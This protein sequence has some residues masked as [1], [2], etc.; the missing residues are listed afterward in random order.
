MAG[1]RGKNEYRFDGDLVRFNLKNGPEAVIDAADYSKIKDFHWCIRRTSTGGIVPEACI[2]TRSAPTE[3]CQ[4]TLGR[5][6]LGA[7]PSDTIRYR[8]GNAL[9]NRRT[10]LYVAGKDLNSVEMYGESIRVWLNKHTYTTIDAEDWPRVN[11]VH[12]TLS[13]QSSHRYAICHSRNHVNKMHRVILKAPDHLEVDHI[14]GDGL[15]NRKCNLRLATRAQ[16]AYN[17]RPMPHNKSGYKG[18][19]R[20]PDGPWTARIRCQLKSI[21]R[22]L[23]FFPTPEAAAHAYDK[24]ALELFGEF[25]YL[26][27][28]DE[29]EKKG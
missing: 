10:N 6:I 4:E 19:S 14:N 12:W 20:H 3:R 26:N 1:K 25:A 21:D 8:N 17:T 27:F 28:P 23:G 29:H 7:T 22:S 24:A 11:N 13:K 2:R 18:V 9:D 5:F 15:D 16:N